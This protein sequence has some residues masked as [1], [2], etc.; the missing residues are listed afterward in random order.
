MSVRVAE[1]HSGE[2]THYIQAKTMEQATAT[3][4]NGEPKPV[5]YRLVSA[6][7]HDAVSKI[8]TDYRMEK[9]NIIV[10]NAGFGNIYGDVTQ[11]KPEEFR[12][13]DEI[14][15]LG[16]RIRPSC[17]LEVANEFEGP[18]LLSQGTQKLL[19]AA[20]CPQYVLLGTPISN[21]ASMEKGP[22]PM[23]A[24]GVRKSVAHYMKRKIHCGMSISTLFS[25]PGFLQT[26]W[27]IT[28]PKTSAT[29]RPLY[30]L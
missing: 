28:A 27:V 22:F 9:L 18:F 17:T 1:S 5:D 24:Y 8:I 13:L 4:H 20:D 10:A 26:I 29:N 3:R 30:Q 23:V 6:I 11:V 25:D 19:E 12:N 2:R 21:I 16:K 14:H 7:L 15:T